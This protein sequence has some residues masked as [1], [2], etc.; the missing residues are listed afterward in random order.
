M[1]IT[2]GSDELDFVLG[3]MDNFIVH[4]EGKTIGGTGCSVAKGPETMEATTVRS[5]EMGKDLVKV[6]KEKRQ[7]AEQEARHEA[8]RK[9]FKYVILANKEQ[10]T[11]NCAYW[12]EK[13]WLK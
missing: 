5:H 1:L 6:I 2:A 8:W 11:Y 3:I 9:R 12:M 10:W 13:D 4:R 7:Y